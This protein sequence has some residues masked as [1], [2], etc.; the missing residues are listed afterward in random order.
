MIEYRY[1]IHGQCIQFKTDSALIA[2]AV[3][4]LLYNLPIESDWVPPDLNICLRKVPSWDT[5]PLSR[6]PGAQK[7]QLKGDLNV[8]ICLPKEWRC[9]LYR[10]GEVKFAHFPGQGFLRIDETGVRAEGYLVNPDAMH[11]EGRTGVF[12]FALSELLKCKGF[13]PVHAAAL[14]KGGRG[15]LISGASGSG[16]TTSCIALLRAG[17]KC[18]TDDSTLLCERREDLQI[19]PFLQKI[20]VTPKTVGFFPEL[21]KAKG[22]LHN[23]VLKQYFYLDQVYPEQMANACK[24]AILL[25]PR[26]MDW[27]QSRLEILSKSRALEDLLPQSVLVFDK[28]V[29]RRQFYVLSRLVQEIDCYNLYFGADILNLPVL[30]DRLLDETQPRCQ[31]RQ[32]L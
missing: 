32:N 8:G 26:V 4:A 23:G 16:K 29:S 19:L 22:L 18:F 25:F 17:Y 12:R 24:P 20:N 7:L 3:Q 31:K 30:I 1:N 6:G 9:D 10:E 15:I 11:P 5:I 2:E 28:E 14:Q 27:P 21:Q 13:Y